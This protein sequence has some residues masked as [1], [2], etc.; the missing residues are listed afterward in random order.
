VPWRQRFSAPA[1]GA[2]PLR[3][4]S[5][6]AW[7]L[8]WRRICSPRL[9]RIS[10]PS[11]VDK[12]RWTPR[13]ETPPSPVLEVSTGFSPQTREAAEADASAAYKQK[14]TRP[15]TAS[16]ASL[17]LLKPSDETVHLTSSPSWRAGVP[18]LQ[19]VHTRPRL[20]FNG[21]SGRGHGA[22]RAS[23]AGHPP[24]QRA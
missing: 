24:Q 7:R 5:R 8:A 19:T 11:D 21:P 20:A 13:G 23:T 22:T 14:Q 10:T 1:A 12:G 17:R 15:Q 16:P 18:A 6:S 4:S 2:Q 9:H 3:P